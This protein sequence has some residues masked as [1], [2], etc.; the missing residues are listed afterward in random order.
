MFA[1]IVRSRLCRRAGVL[2]TG[3]AIALAVS[4]ISASAAGLTF[5]INPSA[6]YAACATV[7]SSQ[8]VSVTF[9]SVG[10]ETGSVPT[11]NAV[12]EATNSG[13]GTSVTLC[14]PG[15]FTAYNGVVEYVLTWRQL[16]GSS[17]SFELACA[18][19]LG[20]FACPGPHGG[21]LPL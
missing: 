2:T 9:T 10:V 13:S 15:G 5:A 19:A 16:S 20:T 12:I 14:L 1:R 8:T 4:P 11:Q 21:T 3:A 18:T 17:G 6:N 7:T